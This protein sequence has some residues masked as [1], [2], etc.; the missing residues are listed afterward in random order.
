MNQRFMIGLLSGL[1]L[2]I[3]VS[4]IFVQ[5]L[6][7]ASQNVVIGIC[8]RVGLVLMT[9]CLA[10]PAI[11]KFRGKPFPRCRRRGHWGLGLFCD[12]PQVASPDHGRSRARARAAFW[13]AVS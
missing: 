6:H 13:N 4:M 3:G 9:C 10:W 1:L 2:L 5:G 7:A 8:I 12:P 11:E